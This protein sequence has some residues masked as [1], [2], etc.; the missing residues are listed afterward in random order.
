MGRRS[1][2]LIIITVYTLKIWQ[3]ILFKISVEGVY[4][5]VRVIVLMPTLTIFQLYRDGQFS[6]SVDYFFYSNV[7]RLYPLPVTPYLIIEGYDIHDNIF[8]C[9]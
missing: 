9:I 6:N 1:T 5:R 3:V 8:Q 2:T 7:H 4:Y